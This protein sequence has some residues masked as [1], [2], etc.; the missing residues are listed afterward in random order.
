SRRGAQLPAL[1]VGA[2]VTQGRQPSVNG[3]RNTVTS[4]SASL[5][6]SWE[7]DLFGKLQRNATAAQARIDARQ[8]QWHDARVSLAAEVADTYV[9]YRGCRQLHNAYERSALSRTRTARVTGISAEAGLTAKADAA[10]ADASLASARAGALNQQMLCELLATSLASLTGLNDAQLRPLI[11]RSASTALPQPA[12]LA[13]SA[14]PAETL[15]QR[16]DL[17]ALERELAATSEEIGAA[18]AAR[19]PALSLSGLISL[20]GAA[21]NALA[22]SWSLGPSVSLPLFDGG[23]RRAAVEIARQSFEIAQAQYRQGVRTAV[24][25]V[26]QAL[27]RLDAVALREVEAIRAAEGY[28][29]TLRAADANWQAGMGSLLSLEDA[30]RSAI[31]SELDVLNLQQARVQYWIA[32][33]K[34]TGGGWTPTPCRQ[35]PAASPTVK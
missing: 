24:K 21:G 8:A 25:E 16:P 18:D 7:I 10:L 17:A 1:G 29:R 27:L 12:A 15:R 14:I 4:R 6:A 22:S 30:R 33:Y 11:D 5:D 2:S 23:Q 19:Y 32:L 34:A 35:C 3:E 20:S 31:A 28:S 13:V 9:Q 26:E